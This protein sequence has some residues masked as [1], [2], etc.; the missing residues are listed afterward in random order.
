LTAL[1]IKG[2]RMSVETGDATIRSGSQSGKA[3]KAGAAGAVVGGLLGGL[4]GGK[5]GAAKGAVGGAAV[6]VTAAA[7]SGQ[8]V[9]VP[10]ETRLSF[11]VKSPPAAPENRVEPVK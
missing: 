3:T 6:G 2:Q 1:E 9:H 7:V 10:S 5:G 11:T 8:K 4:L